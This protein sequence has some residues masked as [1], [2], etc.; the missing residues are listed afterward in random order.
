MKTAI[1]KNEGFANEIHLV[2]PPAL[3]RQLALFPLATGMYVTAIGHFPLAEYH[4][5][6]REHGCEDYIL[7]YCV[8]GNGWFQISDQTQ[9][10]RQHEA[11]V[12]PPNIPHTYGADSQTPWTIYWA[13]F[14]GDHALTYF[15]Y[16]SS[17]NL[18]IPVHVTLRDTLINLFQYVLKSPHQGLTLSNLIHTSS[19]LNHILCSLF[20]ANPAYVPG[21]TA[22]QYKAIEKSIHFMHR[23]KDRPLTLAQLAAQAALSIPHFS[24]LFKLKTGSSPVDF[25]NR[26]R[27]QQACQQL[28]TTNQSVKEVAFSLGYSDPYYFSRSFKKVMGVSPGQYRE[29]F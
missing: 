13:H 24:R 7:I 17:D 23:H 10:V 18:T 6:S 16:L 29:G 14:Q 21:I 4:Y 12:L 5:R 1:R 15:Q 22:P 19:A 8:E 3:N 28:I 27:I 26:L 9:T 20:F 2:V 25:F 11:F